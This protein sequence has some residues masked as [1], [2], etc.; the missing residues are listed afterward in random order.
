[1]CFSHQCSKP[2]LEKR[3]QAHQ[4]K[5]II[6]VILSLLLCAVGRAG[7]DGETNSV[8]TPMPKSYQIRNVKFG[9]LL[10]PDDANSANG[11][12]IVLYSSRP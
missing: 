4:H 6:V 10:R 11:T 12:R 7:A 2:V 9:N 8:P 1:M 3:I 5:N